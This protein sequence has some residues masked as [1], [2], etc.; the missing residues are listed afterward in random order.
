MSQLARDM[1]GRN[2]DM[3]IAVYDLK[4]FLIKNDA[5]IAPSTLTPLLT[6]PL[7]GFSN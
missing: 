4:D 1:E 2:E 7:L 6:Q 5:F 3:D